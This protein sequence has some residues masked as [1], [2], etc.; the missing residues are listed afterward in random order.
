[1]L[2]SSTLRAL[3]PNDKKSKVEHASGFT[4]LWRRSHASPFVQSH[5]LALVVVNYMENRMTFS[6]YFPSMRA[7][8]AVPYQDSLSFSGNECY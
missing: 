6:I 7:G 4:T 8:G 5:V 1:M 3:R 2:A